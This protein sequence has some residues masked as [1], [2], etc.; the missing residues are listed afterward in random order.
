MSPG[1]GLT[2]V[3][4]CRFLAIMGLTKFVRNVFWTHQ[5]K[6]L[7]VYVDLLGLPLLNHTYFLT[8]DPGLIGIPF[9]SNTI[10]GL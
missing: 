7:Q 10:L 9:S 6:L 4:R 5:N 3:L 8:L 1:Y 2:K